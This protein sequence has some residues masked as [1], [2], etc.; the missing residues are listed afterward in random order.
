MTVAGDEDKDSHCSTI[1]DFNVESLPSLTLYPESDTKCGW[2]KCKPEAL[3]KLNTPK[4]F[5]FF[6]VCYSAAQGIYMNFTFELN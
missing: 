3:Q 1:G 2:N 6:L 4:W 5:L